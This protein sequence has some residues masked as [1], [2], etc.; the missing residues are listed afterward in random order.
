MVLH[1]LWSLSHAKSAHL[2]VV[3]AVLLTERR[4]VAHAGRDV[5]RN[6][7]VQWAFLQIAIDAAEL[8]ED[9]VALPVGLHC[10]KAQIY[11]DTQSICFA[12]AQ[13]LLYDQW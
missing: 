4:N 11:N 13:L 10:C 3:R 7:F 9:A 5:Q 6:E 8:L 12:I 1:L 2:P